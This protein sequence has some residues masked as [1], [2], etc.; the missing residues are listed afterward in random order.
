MSV[1]SPFRRRSDSEVARSLERLAD[2]HEE[3]AAR[4]RRIAKALREGRPTLRLRGEWALCDKRGGKRRGAILDW[5]LWKD[6]VW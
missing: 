6:G 3:A 4:V 1:L 5:F 2:D